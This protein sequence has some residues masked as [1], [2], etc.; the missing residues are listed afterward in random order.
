MSS[1]IIDFGKWWLVWSGRNKPAPRYIFA[2]TEIVSVGYPRKVSDLWQATFLNL[3]PT[4]Y[5]VA[6]GP[7][8]RIINLKGGYNPLPPGRYT[9]HYVDKQNRVNHL[10]RTG[11]TTYDGFHVALE[12]V[13]TY[14][15]I[16]PIKAL[17]VQQPVETLLHFVQSDLKE[18]IRSHKYDQL[19]GDMEGNKLENEQIARC[20]KEQ[21]A[22]R[23]QLSRLF[24]IADVVVNEKIGDLKVTEIREKYQI[25]QRQLAAQSEMQRQN[26]ELARKVAEQEAEIRRMK[27]EAEAGLQDTMR[28]LEMQRIELE[29][30]RADF[31][32]RQEKWMRAMDAIGQAFSSPASSRDPQV[33]D[34]IRQLLGTMGATTPAPTLV[35]QADLPG[36]STT[37]PPDPATEEMDS[38]T[39]TL[40][41]LLARKKF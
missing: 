40:F 29:N 38:L 33:M 14:R 20:I 17:E 22:S 21:H 10:P 39:N 35:V 41:S 16:D 28:K 3:H 24:L 19:V 34:V 13:I 18:F 15:V 32:Q 36:D 30:T 7:D 27:L 6:I 12:L 4:H 2:E 23:H 25:D 11:E 37:E 26:Q 8:G 9:I 5:G 31:Q 1:M